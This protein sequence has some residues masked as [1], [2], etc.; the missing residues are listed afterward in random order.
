MSV[1]INISR[2]LE[3]PFSETRDEMEA[4]IGAKKTEIKDTVFHLEEQIAAAMIM[5]AVSTYGLGN[6]VKTLALLAAVIM[7]CDRQKD[8]GRDIENISRQARDLKDK[9]FPSGMRGAY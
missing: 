2:V 9:Y 3:R 7:W 4:L 5:Q 6:K 1:D 8:N